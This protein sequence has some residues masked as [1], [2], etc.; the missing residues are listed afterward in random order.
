MLGLFARR[1]SSGGPTSGIIRPMNDAM[2]NA[3]GDLILQAREVASQL[4]ARESAAEGRSDLAE[5]KL[6]RA[7]DKCATLF[8]VSPRYTESDGDEDRP[9]SNYDGA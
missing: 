8:G 4:D 9:D 5:V 3:L 7:A 6:L 1:V 2:R